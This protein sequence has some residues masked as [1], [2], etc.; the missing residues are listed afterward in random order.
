MAKI[1]YIK[2]VI[3][4]IIIIIIKYNF[5]ITNVETN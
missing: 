4:I 5:I 3:I 1:M 2:P